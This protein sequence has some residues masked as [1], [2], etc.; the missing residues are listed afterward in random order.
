MA[1]NE[2]KKSVTG[3]DQAA[4]RKEAEYDLVT[5]LLEAASYKEDD[6]S[7]TEA[8]I[9]RNGKFLFSV[10]IHPISDEDS[11]FAR[12]KATVYMKNPNGKSL[13][14]I[15]KEFNNAKFKSWVIYIATTEEDQQK[16]WGN[17]ALM[18]KRNL[19]EPWE[20]VGELLTVG[21]KNKLFDLVLEISGMSDDD[22]EEDEEKL[23][24]E[25]YAKN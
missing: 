18:Q 25:E 1:T 15:E 3:L 19:S 24:K 22:G 6:E 14:P 2:E 16:I 12:K 4:D 9:K 5:A 13:P 21:E 20:S 10:H 17:T 7:I 11:R 8:E 23:D